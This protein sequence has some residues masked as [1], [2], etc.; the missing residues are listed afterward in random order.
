MTLKT[1]TRP[2]ERPPK[3]P[4]WM[5]KAL[6]IGL[7]IA[8]LVGLVIAAMK[9]LQGEA[10]LAALRSFQWRYLPLMLLAAASALLLKAWR[11]QLLLQPVYRV[12]WKIP[13]KVFFAGQPAAVLPGGVA[14][15]A[16]MMKEAGADLGRSSAPVLLASLEDQLILVGG[17]LL[18]ALWFEP[19]RMPVAVILGLFGLVALLLWWRPSRHWINQLALRVAGRFNLAHSLRNFQGVLPQLGSPSL[20]ALTLGITAVS[21]AL[22]FAV[23]VLAVWGSGLDLTYWSMFLAFIVPSLLGRVVPVPAGIGV[24]DA[25]MVGFLAA[26]AALDANTAA[27]VVALFRVIMIFL[28]VVVGAIVYFLVWRG[29]REA[30]VHSQ[31][32]TTLDAR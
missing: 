24:V 12:S 11:F 31:T 15:Q 30:V 26:A 27:A 7:T 9:Y 3:P 4:A 8:V 14:A 20:L 19:A 18:A 5:A 13:W 28:P 29:A 16:G 6:K 10:I 2:I 25:S 1:T 23:L 21:F 17:S 22:K 32:V